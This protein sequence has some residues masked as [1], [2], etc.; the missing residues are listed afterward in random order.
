M[1]Y[2]PVNTD[3][4]PDYTFLP[5]YRLQRHSRPATTPACWLLACSTPVSRKASGSRS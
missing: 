2:V 1:M 4:D 3:P 5:V